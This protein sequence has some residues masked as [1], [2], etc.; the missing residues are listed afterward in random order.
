MGFFDSKKEDS[1][2]ENFESSNQIMDIKQIENDL[3]DFYNKSN[4]MHEYTLEAFEAFTELEEFV[5]SN[6]KTREYRELIKGF[7]EENSKCSFRLRVFL[8]E[9]NKVIQ[10]LSLDE[11]SGLQIKKLCY[12]HITNLIIKREKS[13]K[14]NSSN[15]SDIETYRYGGDE[16]VIVISRDIGV[17]VVFIDLM[18][19][20]YFNELGGHK[21][22][23]QAIYVSARIIENT[24]KDFVG[25]SIKTKD[26]LDKVLSNFKMF[27]FDSSF[28]ILNKIL[29]HIDIGY[30]N[31]GELKEIEDKFQKELNRQG[32]SFSSNIL[33]LEEKRE[34]LVELSDIR[35]E[36]QK[37]I[38][39]ILFLLELYKE[40]VLSPEA[41]EVFDGY[42]AFTKKSNL[43]KNFILRIL[44]EG[45]DDKKQFEKIIAEVEKMVIKNNKAMI[46]EKRD[47][48]E[49]VLYEVVLSQ[50]VKNFSK[51]KPEI[52]I[53]NIIK[54]WG[55]D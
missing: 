4:R 28:S 20:N 8:G 54:R 2:K 19:L 23:D 34:I 46:S 29:L 18:Y 17:E 16:F 36:Y 47:Q 31:D 53:N 44:E 37:K 10:K 21:G 32:A 30:S 9:A 22:G 51:K 3:A 42:I 14:L 40:S 50:A 26:I 7:F 49:R 11:V 6:K 33:T 25:K 12:H 43:I 38:A 48:R 15:I 13:Q 1:K 52:D 45:G 5:Q 55:I 41:K 35:S 39:K 24:L 27:K